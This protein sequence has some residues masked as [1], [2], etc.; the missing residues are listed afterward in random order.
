MTMIDSL[1]IRMATSADRPALVRLAELDSVPRSRREA[2]EGGGAD[3]LPP[4]LIAEVDAELRAA[5]PLDGG[6]PI[7][8]P[9]HPTARLISLLRARAE[10]PRAVTPARSQLG[11]RLL[12]PRPAA[13]PGAS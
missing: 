13:T 6:P 2:L 9:F 5:F 3:A 1:T 4:T 10:E 12:D 7:G 8:D 11:R